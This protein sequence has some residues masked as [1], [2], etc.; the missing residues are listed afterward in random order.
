MS[1]PTEEQLMRM[2]QAIKSPRF[3]GFFDRYMEISDAVLC[4]HWKQRGNWKNCEIFMRGGDFESECL[5]RQGYYMS[6]DGKLVP[7]KKRRVIVK[8]KNFK[9]M[10][11]AQSAENKLIMCPLIFVMVMEQTGSLE[12][13]REVI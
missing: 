3:R 13:F 4:S 5:W 7:R 11:P 12:L 8:G 1:E 9:L 10:G 2:V 6:P